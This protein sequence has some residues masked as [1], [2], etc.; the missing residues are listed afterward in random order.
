MSLAHVQAVQKHQLV[1][2]DM[3]VSRV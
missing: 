1:M 2:F 3:T